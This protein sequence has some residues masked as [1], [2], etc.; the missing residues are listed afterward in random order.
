[1][2]Q[3][4][5]SELDYIDEDVAYLLGSIL[6]RGV[7]NYSNGQIVIDYPY[8]YL[9]IDGMPA[10]TSIALS[11]D[12]IVRR[13]Q[14]L[15]FEVLKDPATD[16]RKI[17]LK[18]SAK[19]SSITMRVLGQHLKN[20]TRYQEF[21]VPEAVRDAKDDIVKEF[22]RGYVDV[23]GHVRKSNRDEKGFNR[24]Y[25]DVLFQNWRLPV[26]LCNLLMKRLQVPVH[27]I[28]WGHPNI[29][30]PRARKPSSF[31]RKEHQIKVYAHDFERVGFYID[32]K[33]SLLIKY[34]DENKEMLQKGCKP[35]HESCIVATT[36]SLRRRKKKH[37]KDESDP[38]LPQE[39]RGV[40][41]DDY[42][43]ICKLLGCELIKP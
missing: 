27:T 38:A 23:A 36:R 13:F 29:R 14:D 30:D 4:D 8:K 15:G 6:A 43:E 1:M 42:R 25:I 22:I 2:R 26:Q 39:L 5:I 11:L 33:Q 17:L 19:P 12:P 32:H 9:I 10:Y 37:H 3:H 31:W 21:E 18:L 7:V 40:H 20:R 34:A 16:S 24:V 41:I 28:A 35:S